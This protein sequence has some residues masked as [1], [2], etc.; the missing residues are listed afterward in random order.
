MIPM[1]RFENDLKAISEALERA[2][3]DGFADGAENAKRQVMAAIS[4]APASQPVSATLIEERADVAATVDKPAKSKRQ[5][6]PRGLPRALTLRVM[7]ENKNGVTPQQIVDSAETDFEKMIAVSSIRSEL[8]KGEAKNLY[9]EVDGLWL[10]A[11]SDEAGDSSHKDNSPAS[12]FNNERKQDAPS[13]AS[14]VL[15]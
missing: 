14:S 12:N 11:E 1:E 4:S 9:V 15:D 6:A 7:K 10:S 5:R 8:R 2:Y 3:N 13:V